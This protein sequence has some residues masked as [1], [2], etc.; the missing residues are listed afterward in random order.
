MSAAAYMPGCSDGLI[1]VQVQ[2]DD[3]DKNTQKKPPKF[4]VIPE[5]VRRNVLNS[6]HCTK[7]LTQGVR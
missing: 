5:C 1:G 6:V 3:C 7:Q 4:G 2:N